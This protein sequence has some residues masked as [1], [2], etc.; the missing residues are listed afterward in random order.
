MNNIMDRSGLPNH[1]VTGPILRE[2]EVKG[3]DRNGW[4]KVYWWIT[5]SSR[6]EAMAK[7]KEQFQGYD[8]T[9]SIR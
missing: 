4:C 9:I 1:L 2:Y 3:V 8:L 5:A 7:A 6:S